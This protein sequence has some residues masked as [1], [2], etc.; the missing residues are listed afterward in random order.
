MMSYSD[1]KRVKWDVFVI[2]LA[3][4]NCFFIPFDIAFEPDTPV[5]L[6]VLNT[7]IDIIFL[8]DIFVNFRTTY[9]NKQG[10]EIKDARLIA[11]RYAFGG[12]FIVDLLAVLPLSELYSGD[13]KMLSLC[14][15]L[16]GVLKLIRISRIGKIIGRLDLRD[17]IKAVSKRADS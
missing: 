7:T 13:S 6:Q 16:F 4:W 14:F 11:K 17:D 2:V 10:E 1:S 8:I 15:D 12:R 5:P 3:I 9:F